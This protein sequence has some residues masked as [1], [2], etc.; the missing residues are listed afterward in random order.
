MKTILLSKTLTPLDVGTV[1]NRPLV[2]MLGSSHSFRV[3][4]EASSRK[5]FN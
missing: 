4:R 1:E 3:A 5:S 2:S